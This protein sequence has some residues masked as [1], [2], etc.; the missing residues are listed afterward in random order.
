MSIFDVTL[1]TA[2]R[3]YNGAWYFSIIGAGLTFFSIATV[4]WSAS[5]RD[6]FTEQ[7]IANANA[8]AEQAKEGNAK[9]NER[10]AALEL[11]AEQARL[12]T[13]KIEESNLVIS[14]NLERERLERL[15]LEEVINR[16]KPRALSVS[17]IQLISANLGTAPNGI[18]EIAAEGACSDCSAYSA[19]IAEGFRNAGWNVME[20]SFFG[21]GRRSATG[22]LVKYSENSKN[23]EIEEKVSKSLSSAAIPFEVQQDYISPDP[24]FDFVAARLLIMAI[25]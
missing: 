25:N 11:Q 21:P 23:T 10:A 24:H 12:A 19:Q 9:A 17:Q 22:L 15:R 13:R 5:I 20:G 2:N 3:I 8:T 16:M 7:A 18:I 1:Q 4:F 14:R 6:G